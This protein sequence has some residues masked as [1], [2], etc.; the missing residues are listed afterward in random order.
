MVTFIL[1]RKV[2]PKR[3]TKQI[4]NNRYPSGRRFRL[5]LPYFGIGLFSESKINSFPLLQIAV[6]TGRNK[7]KSNSI[8]PKDNSIDILPLKIYGRDINKDNN[9][10]SNMRFL[11]NLLPDLENF[12]NCFSFK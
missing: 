1:S 4:D 11:K 5:F 6:K 9:K 3:L 8:K 7:R 12:I 10:E 2:K